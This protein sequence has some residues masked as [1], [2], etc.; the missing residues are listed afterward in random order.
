M[1]SVDHNSSVLQW[2]PHSS[3]SAWQMLWGIIE[4]ATIQWWGMKSCF[5]CS[6]F[7]NV[8]CPLSK[9][10]YITVVLV[11][12]WKDIHE[13]MSP[14]ATEENSITAGCFDCMLTSVILESTVVVPSWGKRLWLIKYDH[15]L[16]KVFTYVA[17]IPQ[18]SC[19]RWKKIGGLTFCLPHG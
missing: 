17:V 9:S 13:S 8:S 10:I 2:L 15:T 5:L 19:I 7:F 11:Y 6:S 4:S 18:K 14:S 16:I 3:S 12:M 1:D